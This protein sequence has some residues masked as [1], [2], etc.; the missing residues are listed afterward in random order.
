M[1]HLCNIISDCFIAVFKIKQM[2]ARPKRQPL[3][4]TFKARLS[5]MQRYYSSIA[6]KPLS[7]CG[8]KQCWLPDSKVNIKPEIAEC[9]YFT[10]ADSG[11]RR[12]DDQVYA[13]NKECIN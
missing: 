12:A 7:K 4:F 13:E 1:Y 11:E 2:R 8:H 5:L 3:Q 6:C 10:N 9:A